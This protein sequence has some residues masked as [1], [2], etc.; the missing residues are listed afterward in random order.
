MNTSVKISLGV[1][2]FT[3][4]IFSFC[5]EDPTGPEVIAY[6]WP[7]STP[8]EQGMDS[9]LLTQ[10]ISQGENLGF[11]DCIL[12]I[13]NGFIVAEKYYNGF[14]KD[15]PHNVMSVSKSFLSALT[16]IALRDGHLD[17]LELKM[18]DFFPEYVYPT[19]DPGKFDI[20]VKH[21]LMMRAGFDH[22]QNIYFSVYNSPNWIKTTIELPL[23]Y[24]P[25]TRFAYNTFETHL[26]S[27]IITKASGMSTMAFAKKYL[28]DQ[29]NIVCTQWQQDPQGFYFG[30]NTM[31]FT[32]RDMARLGYL[33]MHDGSLDSKQIIPTEWVEES[34]ANHSNF[35][36]S[37]WGDLDDV[38]YGY[39]W[40]LGEIK[41]QQVFLALGHG[42]QVILNFPE[43]NMIV[44]ATA[45]WQLDWETADQHE[46]AVLSI[47]AN[48]IVPAVNL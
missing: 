13:R 32:P 31:H 3:L 2:L 7:T 46:R 5:S 28:L 36:N 27:A 38:N 41:G 1:L 18:L 44:V 29:M 11:V 23:L 47:V 14:R 24:D 15:T 16:G 39:L 25:G 37:T 26:L 6:N 43:L 30:G 35:N 12:V 40:W 10:A 42:G 22:D 9:Q 8:Q 17:S 48:Y 19:I 45:E 34:I 20:T 21:L 33:Y 4:L